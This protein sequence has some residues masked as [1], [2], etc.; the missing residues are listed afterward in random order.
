MRE[1]SI[2]Y[3]ESCL[4]MYEAAVGAT[5][6]TDLSDILAEIHSMSWEDIGQLFE[7]IKS[8][9]DYYSTH[10]NHFFTR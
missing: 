9:G 5:K 1:V 4:D 2:N 7:R 8:K 6:A 10:F 3:P